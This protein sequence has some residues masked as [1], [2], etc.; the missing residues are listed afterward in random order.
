[1]GIQGVHAANSE[2]DPIALERGVAVLCVCVCVCVPTAM[3]KWTRAVLLQTVN[4]LYR[5]EGNSIMT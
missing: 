3:G 4:R 2:C 1:M 5:L